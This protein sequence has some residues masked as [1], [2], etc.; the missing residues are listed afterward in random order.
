MIY[1]LVSTILIFV[2]VYLMTGDDNTPEGATGRNIICIHH[3]TRS[4]LFQFNFRC[5]DLIDKRLCAKLLDIPL[6]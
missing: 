2:L 3:Q 5:F 4:Y 1:T 6:S